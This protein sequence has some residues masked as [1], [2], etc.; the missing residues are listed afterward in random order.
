MA[1][2]AVGAFELMFSFVPT[3]PMV[4]AF[5]FPPAEFPLAVSDWRNEFDWA[6]GSANDCAT[7]APSEAVFGGWRIAIDVPI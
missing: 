2:K 4:I 3:L 6:C 7:E 1:A 5:E